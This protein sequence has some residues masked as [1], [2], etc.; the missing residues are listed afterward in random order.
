MRPA[1]RG[2][3]A[4]RGASRIW[5]LTASM[6]GLATILAWH[7]VRLPAL[8][9]PVPV[10]WWAL[11][12]LFYVVEVRVVHLQFQREAHSYSLSELPLVAGFFLATPIDLILACVVGSSLGLLVHRRP[13]PIKLAFNVS[14]FALSSAA[15]VS[16]FQ[17]LLLTC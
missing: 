1:F 16:V 4:I 13:A 17:L 2:A 14:L 10:P 12:V 5:L 9:A 8:P 6:A 7:A 3:T 11:A 15:A